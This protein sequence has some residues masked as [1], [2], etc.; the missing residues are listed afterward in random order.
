MN[1]FTYIKY[2]CI[3]KWNSLFSKKEER[4]NIYI[5]EQNPEDKE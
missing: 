1:W 2:M 3:M 4:G 5:Y